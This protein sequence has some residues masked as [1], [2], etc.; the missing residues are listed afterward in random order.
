MIWEMRPEDGDLP[1]VEAGD[2][3]VTGGSVV[4][5]R[6]EGYY[7]V[8]T[9]RPSASSVTVGFSQDVMADPSGSENL[10]TNSLSISFLDIQASPQSEYR[11]FIER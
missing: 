9:V 3:A 4:G 6:G 7:Y 11:F 10:A 5:L 1:D 2:F 8:A